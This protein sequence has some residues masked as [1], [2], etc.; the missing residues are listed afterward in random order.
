MK[1]TGS[2]TVE[3]QIESF[4]GIQGPAGPAGERGK[5]GAAGADGFSPSIALTRI[6]DG[7][8]IK[9][10][11]RDGEHSQIVYDGKDG[12]GAG[13]SAAGEDGGYYMPSVFSDGTLSWLAS[14]A[15]MAAVADA[16]IR[17]PQ[18]EAGAQ[19][20]QGI[21]GEKG[22]KGDAGAAGAQGEQG[23]QGERG[24]QG[25]QGEQGEKGDKGDTGA[26][27]YSPVRGTDYWT[28]ADKAEIKSYVDE[29]ILN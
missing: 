7:V 3:L 15:G 1:I 16:N 17:G 4:R 24:P 21:K 23:E 12:T 5:D 20:P 28:D 22:E 14:K 18:G 25:P 9:V 26:S 29:A 6:A 11:N 2:D 8:L 13:G 19:G 10:M 27:G